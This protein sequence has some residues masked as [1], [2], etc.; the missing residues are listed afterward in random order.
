MVKR[1]L[2]RVGENRYRVLTNNCEHFCNWCLYGRSTSNQV[3][4]FL[5]HPLFAM[6][7]L[8]TL[9]G[10]RALLTPS[11]GKS[12]FEKLAEAEIGVS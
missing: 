1:A 2:S 3:R 4:V 12:L 8:L 11:A 5:T 7:L 6:R 10:G 9:I